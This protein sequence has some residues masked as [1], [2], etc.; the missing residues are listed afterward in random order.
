[1]GRWNRKAHTARIGKHCV[2]FAELLKVVQVKAQT[3]L[4]DSAVIKQ[5]DEQIQALQDTLFHYKPS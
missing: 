4:T 3:T 2:L 1:V 5:L